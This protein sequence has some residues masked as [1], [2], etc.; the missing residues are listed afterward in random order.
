MKKN[1]YTCEI[2]SHEINTADR[3]EGTTPMIIGCN[4]GECDGLA[5]SHFYHC[6]Q[7]IEP[8]SIF[9]KP[10]SNTEWIAIEDE[11]VRDIKNKH[12]Q[13]KERKVEKMKRDFM[14]RIRD[15]VNR[16]G[17]VLLPRKIVESLPSGLK[18]IK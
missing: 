11:L 7:D 18:I 1:K 13:K 10:K 15:H 12:P 6:D 16:G 3:D 4:Q 5:K 17:I 8:E 14:L 2:C 9:I